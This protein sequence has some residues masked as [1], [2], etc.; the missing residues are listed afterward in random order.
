MRAGEDAPRPGRAKHCRRGLLRHALRARS[1]RVRRRRQLRPGSLLLRGQGSDKLAGGYL[2]QGVGSQNDE[3]HTD[4]WADTGTHK[5]AL[6]HLKA[7]DQGIDTVTVDGS[8]IGTVDHYNSTSTN[9][10]YSEITGVSIV[11]A[12]VKSL[13]LQVATKNASASQ[14]G[15]SNQSVKW[16]RTGA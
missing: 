3:Y 8:S 16:I 14:Y 12:G 10:N 13:R 15:H 11:T 6:L 7:G 5:F 4:F 9:N 2:S 1:I